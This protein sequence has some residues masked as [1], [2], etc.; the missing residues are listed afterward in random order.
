MEAQF[1]DVDDRHPGITKLVGRGSLFALPDN[2]G[3][4]AQRNGHNRIRVYITLRAPENWVTESGID[5]N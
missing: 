2:K 5:F 1:S 3:L 4:L